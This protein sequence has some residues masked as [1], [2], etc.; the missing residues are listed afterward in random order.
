MKAES[1]LKYKALSSQCLRAQGCVESS[2]SI[3][4]TGRHFRC[5]LRKGG[6]PSQSARSATRREDD[7]KTTLI[8]SSI[9]RVFVPRS[10]WT[11]AQTYFCRYSC[12]LRTRAHRERLFQFGLLSLLLFVVFFSFSTSFY[13][14]P[15]VGGHE[16]R[17]T[18]IRRVS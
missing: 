10:N 7:S 4:K 18:I 8:Y 14:I 15:C 16:N 12:S 13:P 2:Q 6:H 3:P 11:L 5:P 9:K 1:R 17:Y